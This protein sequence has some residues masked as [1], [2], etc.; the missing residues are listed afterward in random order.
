MRW[1]VPTRHRHHTTGENLISDSR[2][3]ACVVNLETRDLALS[4]LN[5]IGGQSLLLCCL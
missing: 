4:H 3:V 1:Q 5:R 2:V